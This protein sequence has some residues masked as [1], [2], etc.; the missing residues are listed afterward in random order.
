MSIKNNFIKT[1]SVCKVTFSVIAKDANKASVNGDF[2][3]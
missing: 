3:N 2:N 1:K